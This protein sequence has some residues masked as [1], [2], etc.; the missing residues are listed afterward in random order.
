MKSFCV[1]LNCKEIY[2]QMHLNGKLVI[3]T[4]LFCVLSFVTLGQIMKGGNVRILIYVLLHVQSCWGYFISDLQSISI[5]KWYEC[6]VS[7]D[8]IWIICIQRYQY[9][10]HQKRW[11]SSIQKIHNKSTE[12]EVSMTYTL[13]AAVDVCIKN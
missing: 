11:K 3:R 13:S 6:S 2:V 5:I 8:S 10:K 1:V 9:L 4:G 7:I 12:L